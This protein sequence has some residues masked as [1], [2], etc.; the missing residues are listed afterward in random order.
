MGSLW[1]YIARLN[2]FIAIVAIVLVVCGYGWVGVA[3][4]ALALASR[5]HESSLTRVESQHAEALRSLSIRLESL[6]A[7]VESQG[8]VIDSQ[9]KDVN[10]LKTGAR[11]QGGFR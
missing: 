5:A 7:V 10:A 6:Y 2:P 3:S 4:L 9:G 11:L 1:R 8:Q